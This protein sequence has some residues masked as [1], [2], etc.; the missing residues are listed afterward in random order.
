MAIKFVEHRKVAKHLPNPSQVIDG[1][2]KKLDSKVSSEISAKY[3]LVVGLAYELNEEYQKSP[4]VTKEFKKSLN[5]LV[6]FAFDNFEPEMVV[7]LLR[8]IMK[9]YQIKFNVRTDLDTKLRETFS[10]RYIKYIV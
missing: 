7:F 6:S 2:V 1:S 9:D 8:T 3:S 5:N 4:S 10:K